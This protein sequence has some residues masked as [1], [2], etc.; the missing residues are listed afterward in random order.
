MNKLLIFIYGVVC[1]AV[2]FLAFLY[3]V[4][5]VGNLVVPKTI[6]SGP[7][8]NFFIAVF[9]DL[10]LFGFFVGQ[11]TVMARPGFKKRWTRIIP[12]PMERS[13]FVLCASLLLLLLFWQWRPITIVI[14]NVDNVLGKFVLT[15]LFWF[16]WAIVLLATFMIDHFDLFGL[17]QVYLNLRGR[18]YRHGEFTTAGLYRYIR[19]PIMF[20]FIVA[21]WATPLM[22]AGHLLFA[23]ATTVYVLIAIQLEERDLI[24]FIGKDY[25]DYRRRVPMLIPFLGKRKEPED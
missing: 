17:R 4:G 1:Y 12:K 24:G 9:I 22:T 2:F 10:V 21:F 11:H 23:T 7:E 15:G 13:T 18:K 5:F 8:A 25:K 14:W 19:H 20:G 3:A 16:G 6:D